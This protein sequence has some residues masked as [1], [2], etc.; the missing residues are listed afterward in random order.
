MSSTLALGSA[1]RVSVAACRIAAMLC[2]AS[3]RCRLRRACGGAELSPPHSLILPTLSEISEVW[4]DWMRKG[5]GE[6][7]GVSVTR[8]A[9]GPAMR[10]RPSSGG[11]LAIEAGR[12]E[13]R[14]GGRRALAG[15]DLA[16]APGTV[17][18]LLGPNG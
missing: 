8:A 14:F 3:D 4:Q 2:R 15:I 5:A 6:E 18:G 9:P 13:K 12:L 10:S 11:G 1:F 7:P 16:V 17:Y